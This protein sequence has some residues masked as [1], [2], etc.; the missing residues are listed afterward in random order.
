MKCI[1]KKLGVAINDETLPVIKKYVKVP[2]VGYSLQPNLG[3]FSNG[4]F[5]PNS[6]NEGVTC[7]LLLSG[8]D[9]SHKYKLILININNGLSQV[10]QY[11]SDGTGWGDKYLNYKDLTEDSLA[12]DLEITSVSRSLYFANSAEKTVSC[13]LCIFDITSLS[14]EQLSNIN[15][16][17]E[18][19]RNSGEDGLVP[20]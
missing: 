5:T 3:S 6:S 10:K 15:W 16:D 14:A 11:K 13:K 9:V 8:L 7:G 4:V 1:V 20:L 18:Q 12:F 17:D 2:E 19:W